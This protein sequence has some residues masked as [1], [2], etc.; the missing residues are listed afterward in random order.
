MRKIYLSEYVVTIQC[1][2][3]ILA[4]KCSDMF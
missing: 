4:L 1:S 2:H 3:S